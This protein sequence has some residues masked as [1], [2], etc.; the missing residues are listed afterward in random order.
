MGYEF[1]GDPKII[2]TE[3]GSDLVYKGGQPVMDK[4]LENYVIL[5]LFTNEWFANAFI[6][7][8]DEQYISR[9]EDIANRPVTIT[10]FN[11]IRQEVERLL[12]PMIDNKIASEID[13]K[14]SNPRGK[15]LNIDIFI[16]RPGGDVGSLLLT[17][18]GQNWIF[19]INDPAHGR[20]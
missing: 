11:N 2:I 4:G 17:K 12:K 10:T 14:V 19:Q 8:P 3:N 18:N 9:L 5:S 13:V 7:N 6:N 15:L 20:I 1:Q 16:K